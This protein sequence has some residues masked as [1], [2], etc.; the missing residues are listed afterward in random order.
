MHDERRGPGQTLG[1]SAKYR[2]D[3]LCDAFEKAWRHGASPRME[4]F[5]DGVPPVERP[6]LF[7]ELLKLELTLR[8]PATPDE[9]QARFPQFRE[10]IASRFRNPNE[11]E[12]SIERSIRDFTPPRIA[13]VELLEFL[14]DGGMGVVYRAHDAELH[15]IVAVK[16][17][18][19]GPWVRPRDV[20]RFELEARAVAQLNHPNVIQIHRRGT[21]AGVPYFVMEY[22]PNRSLAAR[23]K[24]E[25]QDPKWSA[26][27]IETLAGAV[28]H[29]HDQGIIHRD[30]KPAN[31]LLAADG[32]PKIADFGLA[33]WLTRDA[34]LTH[35]WAVMGTAPYMAPEQAEGRLLDVA[36]CTDVYALGA[37]LFE[38]LTGR[39]PFVADSFEATLRKV[40]DED[41]P[42]PTDLVP[43]LSAE[44][45]AVCLKCLEKRPAQ[46]YTCAAA[47]A[48]D[49][50]RFRD[51]RPLSVLPRSVI[52]QDRRWA[53][54]MGYDIIDQVSHSRGAFVY[55]ARKRG[56][57]KT[58]LLKRC[59]GKPGSEE[60]AVMRAEAEAL[61]E[62]AHPN[63]VRV[64]DAGESA[65]QAY[66][67]SEFVENAAPLNRCRRLD[68]DGDQFLL[69][70][71]CAP[72]APRRAALIALRIALGLQEVHERGFGHG[73]LNAFDIILAGD[74]EPKIA[75][76][77][78]ARRLGA[79]TVPAPP[80]VPPNYLA[81][82]RLARGGA[83]VSVAA[84]VYGLG[85][86]LYDM[87]AGVPPFAASDAICVPEK[88][89]NEP[90]RFP[91]PL[92]RTIPPKLQ[93]FCLKCL[94]KSP[95]AR[96][97]RVSDLLLELQMIIKT[98][99]DSSG[100]T[101]PE[102]G[103][104]PP[105]APGAFQLRIERG[106][107][108]VGKVLRLSEKQVVIGRQS[109]C[110]LVLVDDKKTVSRMHCGV[111]WNRDQQRH[112]LIDYGAY[113]GIT[114][115]GRRIIERTPL[116]TGDRIRITRYTLVFELCSE[117]L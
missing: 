75:G 92:S 15:R 54:R 106:P 114:V 94:A 33:K 55:T 19:A 13:G 115:N 63:I 110:E 72:F 6:A 85:A 102:R 5:L 52:D 8:G 28:Q 61:A 87:L 65:E 77:G 41:P 1:L 66:L 62:L 78:A 53:E 4:A 49:L 2:H 81:P 116:T 79:A 22:A 93:E 98:L 60:Y 82:E 96:F 50:A 40:I 103:E 84:D 69:N 18:K 91:H 44:L 39:P 70:V 67:I 83:P 16:M 113:N 29:F 43:G 97:R 24:R 111:V 107:N 57:P 104:R 37:I 27:L 74:D 89:A 58:V 117:T 86:V 88:V 10:I 64:I 48:D 90:P 109:H 71:P 31:I 21:A 73:A 17:I 20:A 95:A 23:L 7:D 11:D 36:P 76:F 46:R 56:F 32:T 42:R 59:A 112:E 38:I 108:D 99:D 45:E 25:P 68:S 47:L 34:A 3:E 26:G 105:A 12:S 101:N 100:P 9:Y 80:W 14:G 30:L 35:T 51:G